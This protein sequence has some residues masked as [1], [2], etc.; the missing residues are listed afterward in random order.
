MSISRK[1]ELAAVAMLLSLFAFPVLFENILH[2]YSMSGV[3]T[4]IW[5]LFFV[6]T[7]LLLILAPFIPMIRQRRVLPL[8]VVCL[9]LPALAWFVYP[10]CVQACCEYANLNTDEVS[11]EER[12][13]AS[14]G[15]DGSFG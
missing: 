15:L 1:I 4:V 8:D 9:A 11:A 10:R 14:H 5:I 7:T 6:A 2:W 3:G 12:C 13:A